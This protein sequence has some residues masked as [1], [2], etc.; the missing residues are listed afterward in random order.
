MKYIK[1]FE[2]LNEARVLHNDSNPLLDSETIRV[3]HGF[4]SDISALQT[5]K[6]GLSGKTKAKRIYSY[7]AGNNPNGLF[8]TTDFE[9]A[10][11][12]TGGII[13]EFH[14]KVSDL[15]APVWKGGGSYFVSG[16]MTKSF[17]DD[18]DR[19]SEVERQ[20]KLHSDSEN[21][22]IAKSDRPELANVLFDNPEKQA[23]YTGDLDPNSIRAVWVKEEL[24]LNRLNKGDFKRMNS[25]E[26][27]K[28]YG[29]N[30]EKEIDKREKQF[31]DRYTEEFYNF[32][33]KIFKP[34]EDFDIDVAY[35]RINKGMGDKLK[36]DKEEVIDIFKNDVY[37]RDLLLHPKQIKQINKL[38]SDD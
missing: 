34:R 14:T 15:E 31:Q 37:I 17:S 11:K 16:Q 12:F 33:Q 23:L 3:Y 19:Q 21:K 25:K 38:Y 35:D 4:N 13:I 7:E 27:I 36:M 32:K 9:T 24:L 1:T 6:Y 26:F 2:Q 5:I 8:V 29:V 28:K 10:K 22:Q 30:I 20:R 18:D